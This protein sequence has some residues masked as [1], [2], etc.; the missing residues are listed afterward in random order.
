MCECVL[1]LLTVIHIL[2][3]RLHIFKRVTHTHTYVCQVF[4]IS[5]KISTYRIY[6]HFWLL[7]ASYSV[8]ICLYFRSYFFGTLSC[9]VFRMSRAKIFAHSLAEV[10]CCV[11]RFI[12]FDKIRC[13]IRLR[14]CRALP[15]LSYINP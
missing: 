8:N 5:T 6:V 12:Y 4:I 11:A 13:G 2:V 1:Y 10:L 14:G 7:S 9:L 15:V 3:F